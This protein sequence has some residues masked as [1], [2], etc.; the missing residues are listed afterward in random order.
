VISYVVVRRE[1]EIELSM[2]VVKS[3]S[4]APTKLPL[5]AGACL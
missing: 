4:R 1:D 5:R 3:V 2:R